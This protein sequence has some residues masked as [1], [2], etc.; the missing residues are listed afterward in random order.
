MGSVH[1]G[2]I[3]LRFWPAQH[4]WLLRYFV[5]ERVSLAL[6]EFVAVQIFI[7]FNDLHAEIVTV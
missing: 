2:G 6:E 7:Y 5:F 1:A 4:D 3:F